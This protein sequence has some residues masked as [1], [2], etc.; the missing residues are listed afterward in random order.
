MRYG[1]QGV[2]QAAVHV[3]GEIADALSGRSYSSFTEVDATLIQLDG[4]DTKSRLGA[5]AIIGVSLAATAAPAL[6][7]GLTR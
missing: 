4:T 3:N 2:A 6:P 7:Y 1:G 5:N